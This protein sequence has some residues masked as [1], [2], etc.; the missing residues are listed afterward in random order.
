FSLSLTSCLTSCSG[1][2]LTPLILAGCRIPAQSARSSNA[3]QA[4]ASACL[5]MSAGSS[6]D[7]EMNSLDNALIAWGVKSPPGEPEIDF[8]EKIK[9]AGLA[10]A[11]A[12]GG[13]E[14]AFWIISVPLAVVGYHQTTGEWLDLTTLEGKEEAS[15]GGAGGASLFGLTAGFLTFARLVVPLRIALALAL[16]P[17]MDKYIVKGFLKKTDGVDA[18]GDEV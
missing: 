13:T 5:Q 12:Y 15:G 7:E 17:A 1:I 16:T 11:L 8:K 2:L 10:G 18:E 4:R 14:L 9:S 3:P 6:E